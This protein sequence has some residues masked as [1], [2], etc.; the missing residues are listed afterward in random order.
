MIKI[1][2]TQ[3]GYLHAV[4]LWAVTAPMFYDIHILDASGDTLLGP[5]SGDFSEAGFYTIN[6]PSLVEFETGEQYYIMAE[7]DGLGHSDPIPIDDMG[8]MGS[9]YSYISNNGTVWEAT[10]SG[11]LGIGDVGIRARVKSYFDRGDFGF[12]RASGEIGGFAFVEIGEMVSRSAE[13]MNFALIY[14]TPCGGTDEVCVHAYDKLG[15]PITGYPALEQP[16]LLYDMDSFWQGI[17]VEVPAWASPGDKDT[18]IVYTTYYEDGACLD[19]HIDCVDPNEYPGGYF[20]YSADTLVLWISEQTGDE[21]L[22]ELPGSFALHQNNPNPFNP[23]T[24]I[25]FDLPEDSHVELSVYN[26]KGELVSVIADRSMTAG[27]KELTW[28]A[29]DM[30]GRQLSSG[31]YFYRLEAGEFVRTRKMVLLR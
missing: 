11:Y 9:G 30:R 26:V 29:L 31:T 2:P 10:D 17:E 12:F 20:N 15:W 18:I 16:Q 6:L 8:P 27:Y 19:E 22:P 13:V 14:P 25:R 3:Y 1:E 5:I 4:N 28:Q 21:D 24:T 23:S 7:L